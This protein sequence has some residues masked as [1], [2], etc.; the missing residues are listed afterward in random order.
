ML[1]NLGRIS[2][3]TFFGVIFAGTSGAIIVWFGGK[4]ALIYLRMVTGIFMLLLALYIS[5]IWSGLTKLESLGTFLWQFIK[6]VAQ[7]F[8]PLKHPIY[9]LP[10]GFFW[11]WLPCGLVYSTLSWAVS[12]GSA[13]EGGMIMFGFGLGTL[14]SML[15]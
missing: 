3:Y 13:S 6:P 8:I 2:S 1:Y 5:Q 4:D 7:K 14:P 11:G 9:A 12:T 10:L 15:A